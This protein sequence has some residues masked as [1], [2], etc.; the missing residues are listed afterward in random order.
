MRNWKNAM[1]SLLRNLLSQ[2]RN[3][4][5]LASLL[6]SKRHFSSAATVPMIDE[7]VADAADHLFTKSCLCASLGSHG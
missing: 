7:P 4:S 1:T 5:K 2:M 3:F 6:I